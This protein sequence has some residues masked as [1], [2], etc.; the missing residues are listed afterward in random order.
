MFGIIGRTI[1]TT[2]LFRFL[3]LCLLVF[4]YSN[5]YMNSRL[6]CLVLRPCSKSVLHLGNFFHTPVRKNA[7]S[8][9]AARNF[10]VK[11]P[12]FSNLDLSDPKNR[13]F[14]LPPGKFRPKQSLGQNF[15]SDQN[16]VMK[17]V[18]AFSDNSKN[19]HKVVEIGPGPGALTRVLFPR[20]P[21][22]TGIEIDQR[23]VEF[24]G[25]KL[26]GLKVIHED[27]LKT[28]WAE[29]AASKGGRLNVIGNLPYY[30]VS[31]VLFSLVDARKCIDRGVFTMQLEVAERICAKPNTKTYGIP[32]VVFQLYC[33]PTLNFEIPPTVFYPKPKVDSGL[34]T[35]DFK[36]YDKEVDRVN[37]LHLRK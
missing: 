17:I 14:S 27:V 24:L 12:D 5:C 18:D 35:F 2:Y 23:A 34:V 3:C 13:P 4:R 8:F 10:S 19:G 6:S 37:P 16:Y 9:M 30:I 22:M 31:Q 26:P 25:R 33:K 20:Y 21:D 32:S 1:G 36:K 15:L 29:L 11:V 28:N 7:W